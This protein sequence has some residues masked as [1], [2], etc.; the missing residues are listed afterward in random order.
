MTRA[1]YIAKVKVLLDEVSPFDEPEG[2]I[3]SGGD[4]DYAE[5]KPVVSYID[6]CLDRAATCC[7]NELPTT[8]LQG[9]IVVTT[10][11]ASLDPDGVGHVPLPVAHAVR[12]VRLRDNEGVLQRDIT[13]FISTSSP[14]YLLQQN[15]HTRG[16]ACKP[17]AAYRPEDGEMEI[18][19]YYNGGTCYAGN[20]QLGTTLYYIDPLRKAEDVVSPIDEYIALMCAS[21]VEEILGDANAAQVFQSEYKNRLG[22]VGR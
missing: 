16:K 17:V 2:F 20:V 19:S 1:E 12:P 5:V 14:L 3:A 11:T 22:G 15:K 6:G 4:S 21:Y 7:L 13:A 9:D 8:L 18:F 10:L